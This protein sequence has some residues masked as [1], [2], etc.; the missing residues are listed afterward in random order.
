MDACEEHWPAY[1]DVLIQSE[2]R[3]E[4]CQPIILPESDPHLR[5]R[6]ETCGKVEDLMEEA[7]AI[8]VPWH[9]RVLEDGPEAFTSESAAECSEHG[10]E[11]PDS[12]MYAP[13][14]MSKDAK[15]SVVQ[16]QV[17]SRTG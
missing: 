1:E 14:M 5:K 6:K 11:Y 17:Y 13:D 16:G 12:D 3:G 9:R 4:S 10:E 15:A 7:K 8:A 2:S